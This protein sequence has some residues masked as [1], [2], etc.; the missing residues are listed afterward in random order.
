MPIVHLIDPQGYKKVIYDALGKM[1]KLNLISFT[2][3]DNKDFIMLD[4]GKGEFE[5]YELSFEE[6]L[7]LVNINLLKLEV[8]Y[9]C[10]YETPNGGVQYELSKDKKNKMHDDKAYTCAMGAFALAVLRREDLLKD[11]K[12]KTDYSSAPLFSSNI[13]F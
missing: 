2:D 7:A 3:Y 6:K 12:K 13:S 9:M 10:R 4:Q 1:T 8:S 5:T 11:N